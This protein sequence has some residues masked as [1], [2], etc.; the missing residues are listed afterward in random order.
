MKLCPPYTGIMRNLKSYKVPVFPIF[1]TSM[2]ENGENPDSQ[3]VIL[4]S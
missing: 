1:F 2:S 3:A 4:Y